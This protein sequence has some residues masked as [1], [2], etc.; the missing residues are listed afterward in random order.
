M[1]AE[2]STRLPLT[3]ETQDV[4]VLLL[5]LACIAIAGYSLWESNGRNRLAVAIILIALVPVVRRL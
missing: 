5:A 2:V 1:I 3:S 4:I